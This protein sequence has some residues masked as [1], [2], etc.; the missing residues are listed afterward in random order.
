MYICTIYI[1]AIYM[2]FIYIYSSHIYMKFGIQLSLGIPQNQN[3]P[4]SFSFYSQI[5]LQIFH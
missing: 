1:V 3:V 2:K 4:Y 5:I